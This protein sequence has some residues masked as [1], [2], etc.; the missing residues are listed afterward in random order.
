M[1]FDK[2]T[3]I[4]RANSRCALE[5]SRFANRNGLAPLEMT[6][7]LPFLMMFAALMI[8]FGYASTWKVKSEIVARDMVWRNRFPRDAHQD[9]QVNEWPAEAGQGV[10]NGESIK[11]F[12]EYEVLQRPVIVGQIPEVNVSEI[13]VYSRDV[14]VGVSSIVREPPVLPQLGKIDFETEHPILDSR[15]QVYEMGISNETRRIPI[16]YEIGLDFILPSADYQSALAHIEEP[17]H[18]SFLAPLD[19]DPEFIRARG[20]APNFY[21]SV[22]WF[23]STD[24]DWVHENRITASSPSGRRGLL[25]YIEFLPERLIGATIALRDGDMELEEYLYNVLPKIMPRI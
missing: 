15:F 5:R 21:P 24:V 1:N 13:L 9:V 11:S 14:D 22:R 7:V 17:R 19:R 4:D 8:A 20:S 2:S 3:H 25:Y 23:S 6:I 16:I 12:D 18:Q 10:I